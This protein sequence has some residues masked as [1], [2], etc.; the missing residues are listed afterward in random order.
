[1]P[2]GF[3]HASHLKGPTTRHGLPHA[4]GCLEASRSLHG[5]TLASPLAAA[6]EHRPLT[7]VASKYLYSLITC[8]TTLHPRT[9]HKNYTSPESAAQPRP[10]NIRFTSATRCPSPLLFPY[11]CSTFRRLT[12]RWSTH[13]PSLFSSV[14]CSISHSTLAHRII[15]D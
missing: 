12:S 11:L 14:H 13:A 2:N 7:K 4:T 6:S 3:V 10:S 15:H 1:M 9:I 8:C 5:Q